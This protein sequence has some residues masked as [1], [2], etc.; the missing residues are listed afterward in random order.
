MFRLVRARA[1]RAFFN[2]RF[3][4]RRIMED[5][6]VTLESKIAFLEHSVSELSD[7]MA[8]QNT[9]IA[10]LQKKLDILIGMC[11]KISEA[12]DAGDMPHDQRPPHY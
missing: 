5:R 4:G 2:R 6:M 8:S 1:Q 12:G 11:R 9:S 7:A 3:A 10:E